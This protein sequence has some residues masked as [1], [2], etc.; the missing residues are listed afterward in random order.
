MFKT[1]PKEFPVPKLASKFGIASERVEA[2][3][4][5]RGLDRS[6]AAS[7]DI[8][9]KRMPNAREV[10]RLNEYSRL[11]TE[12]E[13]KRGVSAASAGRETQMYEL[14]PEDA[15]ADQGLARAEVERHLRKF[16]AEPPV[17]YEDPFA[18]LP[19]KNVAGPKRFRM[20]FVDVSDNA[21]P[22]K[23]AVWVRAEDGS[24]R[25]VDETEAVRVRRQYASP[26]QMKRA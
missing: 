25:A 26:P 17:S 3:I 2:I 14:T 16:R 24:F 4:K 21:T 20:R 8:F 15:G 10:Q 11:K 22:E 18:N 12:K 23:R 6:T 19:F 5:L 7:P 13:G 9:E 1:Q